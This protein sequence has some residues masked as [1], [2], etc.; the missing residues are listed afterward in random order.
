MAWVSNAWKYTTAF[1]RELHPLINNGEQGS[2][3]CSP[4]EINVKLLRYRGVHL[5]QQTSTM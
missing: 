3:E 1:I 5:K 2:F 4:R